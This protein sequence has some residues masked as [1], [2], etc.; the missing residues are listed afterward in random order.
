M[1]MTAT[2]QVQ[3]LKSHPAQ[4]RTHYDQEGMAALTLQLFQRGLDDWQRAPMR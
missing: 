1:T 4:M 2:T 3:H